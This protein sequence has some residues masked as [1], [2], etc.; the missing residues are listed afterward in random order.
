MPDLNALLLF[1]RVADAESFTLAARQL[2]MPISTLSRKI[3][4]LEESL[5]ARLLER[6]TRRLRLTDL[7]TEFLQHARRAAEVGE[8]VEGLVSEQSAA[9]SG[10]VRLSV[11]P[12]LAEMFLMPLVN[13]FRRAYPAVRVQVLV[14]D[15]FV[16]LV[17]D[18][19]DIAF[20]VGP[21]RDSALVA[22]R[23]LR[24]RH[25]LLASP[26]YCQECKLPRAPHEL[27]DHP[28]LAFSF[29][30]PETRWT[31]ERK[32]RRET[33]SFQPDLAMNDYAGLASAL[34]AGNGIGELPPMIAPSLLAS[35]DL[36]E[37]MPEWRFPEVDLSLLHLGS[38]HIARPVRVFRDFVSESV[39]KLF[40]DLSI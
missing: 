30:T 20:R 35:G 33:L 34:A 15:R 10:L 28:L 1:V 38:R 36:L 37:I 29:W 31:F 13:E 8:A 22:K 24:Y 26:A 21:L 17:A 39:P 25:R 2:G 9:P 23:L 19:V 6:S 7:G 32:E 14:S 4:E 18:G 11:P 5:G 12:S 40:P 27:L 3:G 16:D